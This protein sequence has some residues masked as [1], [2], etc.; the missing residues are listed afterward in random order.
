MKAKLNRYFKDIEEVQV[1]G[2]IL[3]GYSHEKLDKMFKYKVI[4]SL[5]EAFIAE[6]REELLSNFTGTHR[7][8]Y[9]EELRSIAATFNKLQWVPSNIKQGL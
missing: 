5:F 7:A 9:E 2:G 1:L 3:S 4:Q 6:S 8:R